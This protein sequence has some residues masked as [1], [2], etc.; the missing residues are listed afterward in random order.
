M[1]FFQEPREQNEPFLRAPAVVI[2]LI[3]TLVTIHV[4][5]TYLPAKAVD[6]V[7]EHLV[8]VPARY[9]RPFGSIFPL[10]LL[11]PFVGHMFLHASYGHLL[12]NCL[13]L[14]VFGPVVARRY[15]T[16]PFLL[17]YLSAGIAG[18]ATHLAF[19]WGDPLPLVGASGGIAGLMAAGIRMLRPTSVLGVADD[20]P[21]IPIL[22]PRVLLFSAV[23]LVGNLLIGLTGFIGQGSELIAWQAHIGGYAAGLLLSGPFEVLRHRRARR[24]HAG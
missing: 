6:P 21:L 1:A 16:G 14:L 22:S 17:F 5:L 3:L 15:G 23:W 9:A 19:N 7:L 8:F 11:L 13:W 24:L 4:A 2:F 20:A 18:A 12:A 10:D